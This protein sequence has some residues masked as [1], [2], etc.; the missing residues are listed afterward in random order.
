MARTNQCLD[1]KRMK[2]FSSILYDLNKRQ[3]SLELELM[4]ALRLI[5]DL[6]RKNQ[7]LSEEVTRLQRLTALNNVFIALKRDAN[8][9][10][11]PM[12]I[13]TIVNEILEQT[14][15]LKRTCPSDD[16]SPV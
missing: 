1:S 16:T 6:G 13:H 14:K 7:L 9:E 11:E 10:F 3:E 4:Q 12:A 8:G 5:N 2:D 15:N